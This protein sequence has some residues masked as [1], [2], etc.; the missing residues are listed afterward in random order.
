MFSASVRKV[1]RSNGR[2][3]SSLIRA[4]VDSLECRRLLS[5]SLVFITPPTNTTVGSDIDSPNGVQVAVEDASGNVITS[6]AD[7]ISLSLS[8]NSS[9]LTGTTTVQ[10]S[11]GMASFNTLS[12]STSGANY[13][14]TATDAAASL[15]ATSQPFN[16][17]PPLAYGF[18]NIT[19]L[20]SNIS[21]NGGFRPESS[22]YID[23]NGN[24]FGTTTVGGTSGDGTVFEIAEP[25]GVY[26]T[27]I[28]FTGNSGTFPGSDPVAGL[29]SDGNGNLFGT[30]LTGGTSGLGTI[31][32]LAGPSH[33]FS[34][35]LSFT[36]PSGAYPGSAPYAALSSDGN[37]NLF[38]TTEQDG[39]NFDGTLFE[40][41][42]PS[43]TFSTLFSFTGLNGANPGALPEGG[44]T[45]DGN[46]NLY[47]TTT[48]GGTAGFGTVFELS[49][50]SHT[51]T[52]LVSFTNDSGPHFGAG[53][54]GSLAFDSSGNL[55][56]TTNAGTSTT[57]TPLGTVFE[58]SGPGYT[59]FSSLFSFTGNSGAYPGGAP[60]GGLISD[61]SGNLLGTTSFGGTTG[62][63]TVFEL[64]GSSHTFSTLTSFT[65][66]SGAYPGYYLSA[67][68][69]IDANGNMYGTTLSGGLYNS[70]TAFEF[71]SSAPN[72]LTTLI[73]FSGGLGG[74]PRGPVFVD[75]SGNI[76]GTTAGGGTY[77]DGTIFEIAEPSG[78]YSTLVSF[79]GNSGPAPGSDPIT[80]LI[81]DGNGNLYGT[82]QSGGTSG[83]GTVFELTGPSYTFSSLVSFTGN[84]GP[85]LGASPN[86]VLTSDGN[87]N[88]FGTTQ[89]GGTSGDGT[90]FELAGPSHTFST[91]VSFTG[92]SGADPGAS[93]D[94]NASLT[95]DGNGNLFGTTQSGGTSGDGTVFEL[96]GPSYTFS[97]LVSFTGNTGA[98]LGKDPVASLL[99]DANGDLF[100]STYLGSTSGDGTVFELAGPSHTF[101]TLVSFTGNSGAYPGANPDVSLISDG[102]GNL[103]ATT[104]YG[105]PSDNGTVFEL[106]GPSHTFST[107]VS[108]LF[109]TNPYTTPNFNP[110]LVL[111]VNGNLFGTTQYG[112]TSQDG[113]VFELAGPSH[114]FSTLFS[115][116]GNNGAYP[117]DA[118]TPSLTS[119]ANGNLFGTT[120]SGGAS[121]DG[122]V[123]ELTPSTQ[124]SFANPPSGATAGATLPSIQVNIEQSSASISTGD[125]SIVTLSIQSGPSG[126]TLGGT[127]SVQAVNGVAT[128]T[129]LSLNLP[130]NYTLV[131]TDGTLSPATSNPFTIQSNTVTWTGAA[132]GLNWSNPGNWSDDFVP[133]S[134]TNVT[135]GSG[136]TVLLGSGT[137][138]VDSLTASS[139]IEIANAATLL[140]YGPSTFA[141]SLTI[142]NGGAL[143]VA[144]DPVLLLLNGSEF[145]DNGA[146]DLGDSDMIIHNGN[147]AQLISQLISSAATNATTLAV[148]LN[149][150]G[151]GNPLMTS[152]D[153][154]PVTTTDVFV[155]FTYFGDT[156]LDG[157]VTAQDYLAIDNA[158]S[159]NATNPATPLTGWNNGDFNY[160]GVI[161]GDDYTLID[162]AFNSQST[163]PL[164]SKAQPTATTPTIEISAEKLPTASAN[165][166][167]PSN[168][169]VIQPNTAQSIWSIYFDGNDQYIP[170]E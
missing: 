132:D 158:F 112:G 2:V 41:A 88:L 29:T 161:N 147:A 139:P 107:L 72:N 33:T 12:V 40:L 157:S 44:L 111:D 151:N 48:Q 5:N 27:L 106:A 148:E 103:F 94:I 101:S 131:A 25:S 153:N 163:T 35:F 49:G 143:K 20:N 45:S 102:N 36:G 92:N 43:H 30:T 34:S 119:D 117:G 51:F 146:I 9:A 138:S 93:P 91:L 114:V 55:L 95:Q 169:V 164:I 74:S 125:S 98:Y 46:G 116:T 78:V 73:N 66:N 70:G 90:V 31:F 123:F 156:N 62:Y 100:G 23:G 150:D 87:S 122:T 4:V 17:N 3:T 85:S 126:A 16:V 39:K 89:S 38:G 127:T 15:N 121:G 136:F 120:E 53:P 65:G 166:I 96:V 7:N 58:L 37:G 19:S 83:D 124:L 67:G 141:S 64:A 26:S 99:S 168:S 137:Y 144:A 50:P 110:S 115:F 113:T 135:I 97:S 8:P 80:T 149:N 47:G 133:A 142:D 105:G 165:F 104:Q 32:E 1:R 21:L 69:T 152:F 77:L 52:S 130:G 134:N 81:S 11:S 155:K 76:F 75:S 54:I 159:F 86:G 22:L 82:T 109:T 79:S 118:P 59:T 167:N 14:L 28:S 18:Q 68:L 108:F 140:L 154:Q 84:T 56:G 24:I 129:N 42:G 60:Q 63:G 13:T 61:G 145:T 6:N 128:F 160:D 162:N 71:P 170:A 10:A 57:E